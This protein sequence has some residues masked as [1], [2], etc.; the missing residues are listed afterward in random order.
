MSRGLRHWASNAGLGIVCCA[1]LLCGA[2]PGAAAP[3]RLESVLSHD[4]RPIDSSH[5][6]SVHLTSPAD[7][8]LRIE[9]QER[10]ISTVSTL[11]GE[12]PGA[13]NS[14]AAAPV[15]RLGTVVLTAN[16]RRAQATEVGVHAEDSSDIRGEA[17]VSAELIPPG[18]TVRQEAELALAAA[19]RA[20]RATQWSAAFGYYQTAARKFDYLGLHRASA[21]ARSAMAQLAY[22]RFDRKRDAYA[23][24]SMALADY[25]TSADP[26][27]LGALAELEAETLLDMP[28]VDPASVAP[29]VRRWLET[30]Q[31][32]ESTNRYG[33]RELPRV[34]ILTGFLRYLLNEGEPARAAFRRAA[35]SCRDLGDWDCYAVSSQN[36]A[37]LS[38]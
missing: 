14:A 36:L 5:T 31:R 8:L 38:E 30:A 11:N 12:E 26:L 21:M 28:G 4:C 18:D 23:L 13:G 1:L 24:A 10:G 25:G 16:V 20:T 17:C 32:Y 35:Q 27:L 2:Q 9:V 19:G 15:A 6:V 29:A 3:M 37:L 34:E 33:A 7:G 22:W